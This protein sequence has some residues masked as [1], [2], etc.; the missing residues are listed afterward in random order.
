MEESAK[1]MGVGSDEI[2]EVTEDVMISMEPWKL[3]YCASR[4]EKKVSAYLA[5]RDIEYYLPLVKSLRFWKDRKKWVEMPLF[6]GYLFVRPTEIQ[7]DV[8]LTLPG[9]VKYIR[10]NGKDALV[11]AEQVQLIQ[12]LIEKGYQMERYDG[13]EDLER[14]DIAEVLDGVFRGQEVEV[15][16]NTEREESFIIVT[17]E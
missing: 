10:Y 8:V 17:V 7:R 5:Q 6:N 13:D 2:R 15:F 9:V 11:P 1:N 4:Q 3:V 14:G 12:R 16:H